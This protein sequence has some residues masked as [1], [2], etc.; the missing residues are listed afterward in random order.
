MDALSTTAALATT[1]LPVDMPALTVTPTAAP[2]NP[3]AAQVST[4]DCHICVC[5]NRRKPAW[6][7]AGPSKMCVLCVRQYCTVHAAPVDKVGGEDVCEINHETYYW[8]HEARWGEGVHA[9]LYDRK[10]DKWASC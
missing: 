3:T 5:M 6:K 10:C 8:K 9:T 2:T 4:I 7:Q 1:D